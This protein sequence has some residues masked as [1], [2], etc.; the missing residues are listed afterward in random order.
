VT[1]PKG[2]DASGSLGKDW[3]HPVGLCFCAAGLYKGGKFVL[4][5][6]LLAPLHS[7]A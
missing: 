5:S 2:R 3:C 6:M 7:E 1:R 4:V